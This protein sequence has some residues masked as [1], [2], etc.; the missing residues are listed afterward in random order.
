MKKGFFYRYG[1]IFLLMLVFFQQIGAGLYIHNI[2]H[3][4]KSRQSH[5][6]HQELNFT[7]SCV[8]HFLTPFIET[9]EPTFE[10]PLLAVTIVPVRALQKTY[11]TSH[12]IPALRGPPVFIG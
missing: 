7:C 2:W 12:D 3:A 10:R 4:E 8:D 6:Q 5:S 9:V 1:I 11:F